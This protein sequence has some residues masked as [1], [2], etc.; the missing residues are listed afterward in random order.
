MKKLSELQ[1]IK[2]FEI[3]TIILSL[4]G[5]AISLIHGNLYD[6]FLN[7]F[8]IEG[9]V[10]FRLTYISLFLYS[11]LSFVV[12]TSLFFLNEKNPKIR[13]Y[14]FIQGWLL[15]TMAASFYEIFNGMVW[16]ITQNALTK[17]LLEYPYHFATKAPNVIFFGA[18]FV[19]WILEKGKKIKQ[20]QIPSDRN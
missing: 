3:I 17:Q 7:L 18:L 9:I 8:S 1:R 12:F 4:L 6:Y 14:S 20:R 19:F 15:L 2:V 13:W 10:N 11:T 5:M 16:W